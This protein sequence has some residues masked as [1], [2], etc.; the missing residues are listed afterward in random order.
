[1]AGTLADT[2]VFIA[3]FKGHRRLG[4]RI[5]VDRPA[6]STIVYLELIQGSKNKT[7]V[8]KIEKLLRFFKVIHFDEAIGLRAIDLIRKYSKSNGLLLADAI[9]AATCLENE[10]RLVTFNAKDFHFIQGLAIDVPKP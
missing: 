9:I 6:L 10:L 1:M 2:N 4:E 5:K 3:V 7:E 8:R